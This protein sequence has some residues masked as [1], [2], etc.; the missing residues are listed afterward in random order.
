[1][2]VVVLALQLS[3]TV[4]ERTVFRLHFNDLPPVECEMFVVGDVAELVAEAVGGADGLVDV[5]VGVAVDP[6]VDS[7][8]GDVVGQLDGECAVDAAALKLGC[9][10]L[11]G[12]DVMGDDDFALGLAGADGLLDEV[13]AALMLTVE[14]GIPQ[15]VVAIDDAVK[16]GHAPLG[17]EGVVQVD[18][19]PQSGN[20]EVHVLDRD[21]LVIVI[22]DVGADFA[23]QSVVHRLQVVVFIKLVVA[24]RDQHL[25]VVLGRP[26]PERMHTVHV[27]AQVARVTGQDHDIALHVHGAVIP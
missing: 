1:M 19:R 14:I 21:D 5:A 18:M 9:D 22:M 4:T 2:L 6:V 25:L 10:Q 17:D 3:Y 15:Q 26:V 7:A 24:Q 23:H 8:G 27:V 13:E 20:D 11:I 12:W 16:V